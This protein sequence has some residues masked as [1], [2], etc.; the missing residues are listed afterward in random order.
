MRDLSVDSGS[1]QDLD[2]GNGATPLMRADAISFVSRGQS[3]LNRL[4]IDFH[5]GRI[6]SILGANGAGKSLLVRTLHGLLK[7]S[8]G[9]VLWSG[10]PLDRMAR[11]QQA[12]VFQRPVMM[13][14]SA[15]ANLRF[16]L[17]VRGVPRR[18]RAGLCEEALE[19]TGLSHLAHRPALS[20]SGGEQ[21][22]LAIARALLC[23]PRLLFLD[24]PTA[25]LDPASTHAVEVLIQKAHADGVSVVLVTHD[26]GQARRLSDDV[27]FLHQGQVAEAGRAARL[28]H[29]PQSEALRAWLDGRLYIPK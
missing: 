26:S 9:Q 11:R 8:S 19:V 25:S 2:M 29:T 3:L 15:L 14:R 22:R 20:L 27:V 16:A 13:R 18:D 10:Q 21:Q 1:F 28:L 5:Q 24:E 7:P 4:S 6:V 17:F 23:K 12:M